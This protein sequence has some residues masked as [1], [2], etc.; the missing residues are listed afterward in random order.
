MRPFDFLKF[1]AV[2]E[3]I[4]KVERTLLEKL[5]VDR[6]IELLENESADRPAVARSDS[7]LMMRPRG[8][9]DYLPVDDS[10]DFN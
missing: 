7:L 9:L 2:K 4:E 8:E 5:T 1:Y 10:I 3:A 6:Q